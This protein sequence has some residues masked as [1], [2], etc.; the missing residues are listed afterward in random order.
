MPGAAFVNPGTPLREAL[1]RA[2][3]MRVAGMAK[4]GSAPLA[5][6]VSEKAILNGIV[7]LM[8]TGGSTN[9][10][11]HLIAMAR[12]AGI[13]V[14]WDDFDDLS[15]ATPLLARVYPNGSADVN[16][17]H[18][19]GGLGFVIRELL[20]AGLLHGDFA[21]VFG[22]GLA[23]YAKEPFLKDGVLQ[24]RDAPKE[25]LDRDILR[26]VSDPF[27]SDGGIRLVKGN[28]G[29][30]IIKVS[31]VAPE[32]RMVE[33]PAR[34]FDDQ[35]DL[36]AAF[37]AGKLGSDMIAVVRFQ[38]PRANGMPELHKLT[39]ALTVLQD[40]GFKV[41]LVS[42]GRMS[43]ASGRVPA[44]IHVSPEALGGGPLA[45]LKDGDIVRL[46]AERGVLEAKVSPTELAARAPARPTHESDFGMGRELFRRNRDNASMPE[47][48][49][50][51]LF[52]EKEDMA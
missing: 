38:G 14:T 47:T 13:I 48:G 16:Q 24:W 20:A 12:A 45:R 4:E 3:A 46:D 2:A 36:L 39:P 7:G 6:T 19:A 15:R 23:A 10:T 9:H 1:T 25:S 18:A 30:G 50:Q 28:L 52:P 5:H 37:K 32:H 17:F 22:G 33:A 42:D 43:G 35:D 21:T 31:A 44:A 41:A 27:Q 29:R 26:P 34:I 51:T 40:R 49:G 8:A 11:I